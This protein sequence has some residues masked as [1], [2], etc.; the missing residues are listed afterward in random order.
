MER[1]Q[2]DAINRCVD[3]KSLKVKRGSRKRDL[4]RFHTHVALV[5]AQLLSKVSWSEWGRKYADYQM[6]GRLCHL[7]QERI[8]ELLQDESQSAELE[9]ETNDWESFL[10]AWQERDVLVRSLQ[11]QRDMYVL[12]LAGQDTIESLSRYAPCTGPD[13]DALLATL[14]GQVDAL[15]VGLRDAVQSGE[16]DALYEEILSKFLMYQDRIRRDT[17]AST[18]VAPTTTVAPAATTDHASPF[19][20]KLRTTL[21][22]FQGDVVDWR[23]FWEVYQ[24]K[25]RKE[26]SLSAWDRIT[27]LQSCL[28]DSEALKLFTKAAHGGQYDAGVKALEAAYG[29]PRMVVRHL[30]Q[31]LLASPPL[32]Q[33]NKV[34]V[35]TKS[36]LTDLIA[37]FEG[38]KV[39]TIGQLLV[40]LVE[41]FMEKSTRKLWL[42][43]TKK[44]IDPPDIAIMQEFLDERD[45]ATQSTIGPSTSDP[46]HGLQKSKPPPTDPKY[47][48]EFKP[49]RGEEPPTQC[50]QLLPRPSV[51]YVRWEASRVRLRDLQSHGP[52]RK[53]ASSPAER[54]LLQLS[55]QRTCREG[56]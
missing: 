32:S 19:T 5:S 36:L 23:G 8:L 11:E 37:G 9:K 25:M 16:L 53:E 14:R 35:Q 52:G 29:R 56:L 39:N 33:S 17:P 10:D 12:A 27:C 50:T 45:N 22:K 41:H 40:A 30:V 47:P 3:A 55:W 38:A 18:V 43:F 6:A 1:E 46:H 26:T 34:V 49:V 42:E 13:V 54:S 24:E 31:N 21:P 4:A 44:E 28:D 2:I 20:V 51:Q 7:T 48:K 15:K